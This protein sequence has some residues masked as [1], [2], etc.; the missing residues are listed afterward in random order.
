MRLI[1]P[2]INVFKEPAYL[3]YY[4]RQLSREFRLF[5]FDYRFLD[6]YSFPP[7]SICLI[8]T[9]RCNL[10]CVMCDI[11]QK[12]AKNSTT[13][14]FPLTASINKGESALKLE[15][16]KQLVDDI[17]AKQWDP[18]LLLTGTEP[19]LY[20]Q[21]TELIDYIVAS[22]LRLHITT[23]G[24]LLSRYAENVV[25]LCTK[26]GSITLTISL[27]GIGE[28]HDSIRGV[29]GTFERAVK[30]L[31]AIDERKKRLDSK[32]PEVSLC[33]TISNFN[34]HHI[35]EFV[36]WFYRRDFGLESITFSHLWFKDKTIVEK[37]NQ[38]HG[39]Q[40]LIQ[41]ANLTGLNIAAIDMDSVAE[42]LRTIRE[43]Y[44]DLPF[45]LFEQPLLTAEESQKYY[46]Q[47]TE[48]VFYEK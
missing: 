1:K 21:V 7:K 13:A 35:N 32:W 48:V 2:L 39:K 47:P 40:C 29:R 4:W 44:N 6:G 25:D 16:W 20:P 27:D 43:S 26:P 8:L 46:T 33:Y 37:H 12:N 5:D 19:F 28:V 14:S 41:Q 34:D 18:L 22:N 23:N 38:K 45:A 9:E 42:Q 3:P 31:Q 36:N 30:G 11:G 24:T 15:N 17:V 10:Q